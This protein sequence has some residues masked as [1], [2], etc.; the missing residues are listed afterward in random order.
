L[1]IGAGYLAQLLVMQVQKWEFRHNDVVGDASSVS[2]YVASSYR[3]PVTSAPS[4]TSLHTARTH[5]CSLQAL[6]SALI[7]SFF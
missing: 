1:R 4:R 5:L 2:L 3:V 7:C 6:L